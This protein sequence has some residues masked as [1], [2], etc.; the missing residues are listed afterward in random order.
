MKH[1]IIFLKFYI[2]DLCSLYGKEESF[3]RGMY[4][5]KKSRGFFSSIWVIVIY[6]TTKELIAHIHCTFLFTVGICSMATTRAKSPLGPY[7]LGMLS[8]WMKITKCNILI[9][10]PAYYHVTCRI[11]L[12]IINMHLHCTWVLCS[13]MAQLL[14]HSSVAQQMYLS[15]AVDD[16]V[17]NDLVT[18]WPPA[19]IYMVI[20]NLVLHGNCY[21]ISPWIKW[22]PFWQTTFSNAFSCMKMI[23]F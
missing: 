16:I 6:L 9:R 1:P 7:M 2:N 18:Q 17:V 15:C 14:N 23:E 8:I 11:V 21:L 13:E 3:T 22:P 5:H 20:I 12:N 4:D 19:A 10:S